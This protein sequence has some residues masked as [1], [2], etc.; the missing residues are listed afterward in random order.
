V[1]LVEVVAGGV[2][3]LVP[4]LWPIAVDVAVFP[5][6]GVT[7]FIFNGREFVVVIGRVGVFVVG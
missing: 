3:D 6:G 5:G 1:F 4:N 7:D 2:S